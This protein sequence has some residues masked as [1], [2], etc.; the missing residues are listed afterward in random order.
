MEEEQVDLK[1]VAT[2]LNWVMA[3][4]KTEIAPKLNEKIL[5]VRDQGIVQI[6]FGVTPGQVE[7][8]DE[9]AVFEDRCGVGMKFS[10]AVVTSFTG[11]SA[12]RSN[13][14]PAS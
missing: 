8:F 6:G 7:K 1:I 3:A 12:I 2:D 4:D 5:E 11:E 14:A 9:I 10:S 13:R